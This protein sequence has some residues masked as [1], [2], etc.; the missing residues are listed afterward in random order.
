MPI[1]PDEEKRTVRNGWRLLAWPAIARQL[2]ELGRE[3]R[4]LAEADPNGYKQHPQVKL[5]AVIRRLLLEIIPADPNGHAL[6]LGNTLG[7]EH[8]HW[9]RAKF[10]G[11]FRLFFRFHS[12]TRT[13]IYVWMNDENTLRK[14]GGRT[15][16]YA[17]FYQMLERGKP[18]SE[19]E[20][21][22]GQ[23]DDL[24]DAVI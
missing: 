10:S 21:L 13:I 6:Q 20:D 1:S 14:S 18:P 4:R 15:D 7:P 12:A 2:E 5:L 19:W 9:R 17:V 8:R 16:P 22:L 23:S 3:V 11:R 24:N